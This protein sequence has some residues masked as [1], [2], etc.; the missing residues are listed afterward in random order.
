MKKSSDDDDKGGMQILSHTHT[1]LVKSF[2]PDDFT[3]IEVQELCLSH[4]CRA[5]TPES[6][7]NLGEF[8][9]KAVGSKRVKQ[10][11]YIISAINHSPSRPL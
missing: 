10:L 4:K 11:L 3:P 1:R 5:V 6:W 7:D 8:V 2:L 9:E